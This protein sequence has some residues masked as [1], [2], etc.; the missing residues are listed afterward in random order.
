[1]KWPFVPEKWQYKR[2]LSASDKTNLN[3]LIAE[4][5]SPLLVK[6]LQTLEVLLLVSMCSYS[7]KVL[8]LAD[9]LKG[10]HRRSGATHLAGS[11]V[12][13]RPLSLL[14]GQVQPA[15]KDHQLAPQASPW[16]SHRTTAGHT[17]GQSIPQLWYTQSLLSLTG[18][19]TI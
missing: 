7:I 1:M 13:S 2:A 16:S 14:G 9:C 10:F 12:L 5:I 3:D 17:K 19:V 15:A 18:G 6:G 8:W 11:R 4:H